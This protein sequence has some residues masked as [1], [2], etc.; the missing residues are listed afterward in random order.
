MWNYER[1]FFLT[2][3]FFQIVFIIVQFVKKETQLL[4]RKMDKDLKKE[5]FCYNCSDF[6]LAKTKEPMKQPDRWLP[7][8]LY[9][10][11]SFLYASA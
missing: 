6:F 4:I 10:I 2:L 3:R 7:L 1:S 9:L 11:C 5:R 8:L